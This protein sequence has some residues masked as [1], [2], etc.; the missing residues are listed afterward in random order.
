M[1]GAT[2]SD[3]G[4]DQC[5]KSDRARLTLRAYHGHSRAWHGY[6]VADTRP[7]RPTAG[8]KYVG[9]FRDWLTGRPKVIKALEAAPEGESSF[10]RVIAEF[11]NRDGKDLYS[12]VFGGTEPLRSEPCSIGLKPTLCRQIHFSLDEYRYWMA[13]MRREPRF[14]RKEWELFYI[15]QCLFEAGMLKPGRRGLAFAV[16]REPLPALFA[17]RGCEILATDQAIDKAV[18]SGWANSGQHSVQLN[19]LY[20]EGVCDRAS[21]HDHVQFRALDMNDLPADLDG[22]FDFCWSTCSFE[23]LGSLEYGLRFVENAMRVLKPGGIA[24]HTTEYN[25]S[26]NDDTMETPGLSI[27]RRRDIENLVE[28]LRSRGHRADSVDFEAGHGFVESIVDL[29][30]YRQSPHLRL[31]LDRFHCTS[32][33]LLAVAGS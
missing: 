14:H 21:F 24:I 6:V 12:A 2:N 33:G 8:A 7:L 13:A 9:P 28:R 4:P 17:S 31:M 19:D 10:A 27:Y 15:S 16:G 29:P 11:D 30:P 5:S 25:L 22:E 20:V 32:V 3:M 23:H 1:R 18:E 26:S